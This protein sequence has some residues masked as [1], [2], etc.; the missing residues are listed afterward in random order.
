MPGE[1]QRSLGEARGKQPGRSASI[2][3]CSADIYADR[4]ATMDGDAEIAAVCG[5]NS[6]LFFPGSVKDRPALNMIAAAEA[7][8]FA[9]AL[10][11]LRPS[12]THHV[13]FAATLTCDLTCTGEIQPGRDTLIEATSGNTG[14]LPLPLSLS[15]SLSS[16]LPLSLSPSPSLPLSLSLSLSPSPS[17][18]L[19]PSPHCLH[20]TGGV[21]AGRR[22]RQRDARPRQRVSYPTPLPPSYAVPATHL[23]VLSYASAMLSPVLTYHKTS[24]TGPP[25]L[26]MRSP[27]LTYPYSPVPRPRQRV[28]LPY[29]LSLPMSSPVLTY[30]YSPMFFLCALSPLAYAYC[31]TPFLR[32]RRY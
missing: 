18:S 9:H 16:S 10:I 25:P 27:L 4:S 2:H 3:A 20:G 15:P 28:R 17:P 23:P 13:H 11:L 24:A 32:H 26:P 30:P 5:G 19:A 31:P 12:C 7:R 21:G 29:L 1:F 14:L 22:R 8:G 6:D